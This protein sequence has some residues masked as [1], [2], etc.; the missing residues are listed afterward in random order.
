MVVKKLRIPEFGGRVGQSESVANRPDRPRHPSAGNLNEP[1]QAAPTQADDTTLSTLTYPTGAPFD[2]SRV[3]FG[4]GLADD[5]LDRLIGAA[6]GK[7]VLELGSGDGS[8]AIALAKAGARVIVVESSASR[9]AVA[10]ANAEAAGVRVEFHHSDLAELVNVRADRLDFCIAIYSLS[11]V[12]D[13]S[14]VF[15]QVHRL[16]RPEAPMVISLPHPLEIQTSVGQPDDGTPVLSR[17]AFD[18]TR[19]LV[20]PQQTPIEAHRIADMVTALTRS[21]FRVDTV[22]E[23]PMGQADGGVFRAPRHQLIPATVIFRG[24]KLG[25]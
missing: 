2:P 18:D 25:T 6:D 20:G 23:P 11:T 5:I 4:P 13:V 22:L 15:R 14:R 9:L 12:A 21:N 17:S 16:L 8:N 3:R 24:R 7:R 1:R 19:V 10:R